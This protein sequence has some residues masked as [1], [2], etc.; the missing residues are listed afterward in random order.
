MLLLKIDQEV[1]KW[2]RREGIVVAGKLESRN[3]TGDDDYA[4]ADSLA[5]GGCHNLQSNLH[6][7]DCTHS[8]NKLWDRRADL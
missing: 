1:R 4:L 3:S 8:Q 6:S 2:R 7:I 5:D